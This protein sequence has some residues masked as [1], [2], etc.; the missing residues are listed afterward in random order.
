[1]LTE[2]DAA[3][4]GA[5]AFFPPFDGAGFE[6]VTREAQRADDG[7]AFAFVTYRRVR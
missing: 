1:V 7:T 2:I 5:D 6:P 4:D 3:F